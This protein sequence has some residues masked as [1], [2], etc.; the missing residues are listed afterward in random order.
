[1]FYI[2]LWRDQ[3]CLVLRSSSWVN[4]TPCTGVL[5]WNQEGVLLLVASELHVDHLGG[6]TGLHIRWRLRNHFVRSPDG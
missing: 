5:N 2:Q 1:M 6:V 4:N 3:I